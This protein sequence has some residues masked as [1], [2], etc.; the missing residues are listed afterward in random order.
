MSD[1]AESAGVSQGLAYRYFPSKEALF[2]ELIEQA[3]QSGM[4][5]MQQVQKL[6]GTPGERLNFLISK[7]LEN[8]REHIEFY[9]FSAQIFDDETMPEDSRNLLRK[10]GSAYQKLMRQMIV[11]AQAAGEIAAD[12]PDQLLMVITACLDGLLAMRNSAQF[13]KQ[14]PEAEIILRILKP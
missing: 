6:S 3:T 7:S 9:Q 11:E 13:K 10:Y 1:V 12:D 8:M 4:A 14:F 2:K 5:L